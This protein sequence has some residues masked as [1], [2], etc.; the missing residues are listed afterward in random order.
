MD[1]LNNL[2]LESLLTHIIKTAS[3]EEYDNLLHAEEADCMSLQNLLQLA[4]FLVSFGLVALVDNFID[5]G[6]QLN[7]EC[8]QVDS[9]RHFFVIYTNF[10][11]S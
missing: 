10:N 3:N 11:T 4:M 8:L 1:G 2:R 6:D 7:A 5:L 9:H